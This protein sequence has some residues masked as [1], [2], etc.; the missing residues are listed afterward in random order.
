MNASDR[1]LILENFSER[2]I[3]NLK[4]NVFLFWF[5]IDCKTVVIQ[6]SVRLVSGF[7]HGWS[8]KEVLANHECLY[9]QKYVNVVYELGDYAS[10]LLLV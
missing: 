10:F 3:T 1:I 5:E 2:F 8:R 9:S 4:V 7:M 6:A